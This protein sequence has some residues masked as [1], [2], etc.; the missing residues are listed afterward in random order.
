MYGLRWGQLPL[1]SCCHLSSGHKDS[2][3]RGAWVP[4]EEDPG[5]VSSEVWT[6]LE[7]RGPG[8]EVAVVPHQWDSLEIHLG[9]CWNYAPW[10][11]RQ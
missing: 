2:S 5:P 6:F 10:W 4:E 7:S 9:I 8:R 1:E 11:L 3:L